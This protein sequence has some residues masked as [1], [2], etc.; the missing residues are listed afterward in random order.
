M[1]RT[2]VLLAAAVASAAFALVPTAE[3][4]PPGAV[5]WWTQRPG[6]APR[7]DGGI[8]VAASLR[9]DES[10]AA[11]RIDELPGG[12]TPTQLV[13]TEAPSTTGIAALKACRATSAWEPA[14]GGAFESQPTADCA[15]AVEVVSDGA[16]EWT[17]DLGPLLNGATADVVLLPDPP[18]VVPGLPGIGFTIAFTGIDVVTSSG[19]APPLPAPVTTAVAVA[20]RPSPSPSPAA[21]PVRP[22]PVPA[23]VPTTVAGVGNDGSGGSL[24]S[25]V[26]PGATVPALMFD[27]ASNAEERPWGRLLLLVPLS[28][29]AGFGAAAA[30]NA[31]RERGL[32]ALAG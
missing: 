19:A 23:G 21:S 15:T 3:A 32:G 4:D 10:V 16:G 17:V 12:G 22:S 24:G 5:G 27:L 7:T 8:E 30:R 25:P 29:A 9:G 1:N 18:E 6:A 14:D 28:V 2:R 20:P 11:I 26:A 13:L 31:A